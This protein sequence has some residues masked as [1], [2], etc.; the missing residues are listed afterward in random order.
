GESA[1]VP[2]V[3]G[4]AEAR[5]RIADRVTEADL[6][7]ATPPPAEDE[8][9]GLGELEAAGITPSVGQRTEM[10]LRGDDRLPAS[11]LT[12]LDLTR[13]RMTGPGTWT[14]ASEEAAA[15]AAR[16]LWARAYAGF[17]DAVPEGTD[18]AEASRAWSAA[19]VLVLPAEPHDVLADSRY[20]GEDFRDA[21]R[22]VADRV[23]AGGGDAWSA[24]GPAD[25]LRRELG[26]LPR[27]TTP[28]PDA[29]TTAEDPA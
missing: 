9:V 11:A 2:S 4:D 18:E 8:T 27:W 12:P 16:R 6:P 15:N 25:T 20:A 19:V 24:A 28:G 14:A 3:P 13:V 17:A 5:R 22:R 7:S 26:L 23:L 21:V 29:R 1:G 10:T